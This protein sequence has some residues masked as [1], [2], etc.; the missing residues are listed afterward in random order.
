MA[1]S[2][3]DGAVVVPQALVETVTAEAAEQEKFESWVFTQ[4]QAGASLPGLYP[5]NKETKARYEAFRNA[6]SKARE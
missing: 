1:E 5:P 4:V 2:V 3:P 6:K